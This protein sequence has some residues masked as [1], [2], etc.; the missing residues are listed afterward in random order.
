MIV[1][2]IVMMVIALLGALLDVDEGDQAG[3]KVGQFLKRKVLGQLLVHRHD[4]RCRRLGCE[5]SLLGQFEVIETM[6]ARA[7]AWA[8]ARGSWAPGPGSEACGRIVR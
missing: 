6:L 8:W 1:I 3:A 7:G 4:T 5:A 2:V